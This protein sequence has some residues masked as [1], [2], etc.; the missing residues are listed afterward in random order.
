MEVLGSIFTSWG[1]IIAEAQKSAMGLAALIVL[2]I[3][4]I[5]LVSLHRM[6][7]KYVGPASLVGIVLLVMSVVWA[8]P[9]FVLFANIPKPPS[10]VY[11]AEVLQHLK[12]V[13]FKVPYRGDDSV[14]YTLYDG[15]LERQSGD[16]WQE[17]KTE[18]M[19]ARRYIGSTRSASPRPKSTFI[20][21]T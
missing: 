21:K 10:F 6:P 4:A 11:T 3:T 18:L 20:D 13:D 7:R 17:T 1:A 12:K 2:T 8:L 15:R 5:S 16:E 9:A 19:V 14:K